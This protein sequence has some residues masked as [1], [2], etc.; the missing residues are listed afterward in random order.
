MP[1]LGILVGGGPAPGINGVIGA[2]AIEA[3]NEGCSVVGIY[4]GYRWLAR[5]DATHAVSLRIEDV[6]RIHW[7]GGSILR[8][9]RT[10]PAHDATTVTNCVTALRA[11]NITHLL[12]IGGDDTTFGAAK[13]AEATGGSIH[14]ATVPKTIDNDLPLPDNMPTFGFE[15]ARAVGAGIVET[16]MEDARTT[17]RWYLVISMGRKS[18]ALALGITKAAG[19]TVAIIPEQ[20]QDTT[21]S[22]GLVADVIVGSMIKRA[23]SG[24]EHGVAVIAEGIAEGL[25]ERDFAGMHDAP[26]DAYGH[27]RLSE[28]DVGAVL[29]HA[30]AA[31]LKELRL[32]IDIVTKDVG[33]ELRCAKPLPFDVEYTRTL[34]YGAVRYLLGGGSGAMVALRGGHVAPVPLQDM[35]DPDS[36]RIRVRLVDT[37]TEAYEVSRKYTIRIEQADLEQPRLGPLASR[38]GLTPAEFRSRFAA[39]TVVL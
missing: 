32:E 30:V 22:I 10:N 3:I 21:L 6:S 1:T 4:D 26:R 16:L 34:G 39:S 7:T 33:Y 11:L 36:G 27:I 18:G 35:I 31:R 15:T 29:K 8:T 20:F 37:T 38:V 24:A 17:L 5:G 19:A 12:C 14:V 13:I 23:V 2:A 25:D 9:A 28:I